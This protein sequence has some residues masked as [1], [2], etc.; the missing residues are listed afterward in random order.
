MRAVSARSESAPSSPN[1]GRAPLVRG[2]VVRVLGNG[3]LVT[4]RL[5]IVFVVIVIVIVI[6]V[7]MLVRVRDS[8]EVFVH[9]EMAMVRIAM[10]VVVHE[11]VFRGARP[12]LPPA[13]GDVWRSQTS[14]SG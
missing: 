7:A 6:L 5:P 12:H 10:I 4:V 14:G 2:P 8:I 9:V 1:R 3:V 11:C 13:R